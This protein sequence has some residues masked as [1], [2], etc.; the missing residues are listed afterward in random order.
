M[1]IVKIQDKESLVRD[2]TSG[3]IINTDKTE[4]E[5]YLI[6]RNASKQMKLQIEKNSEEIAEIKNDISEIKQLLIS[7]I[8][9]ER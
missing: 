5:N 3:A 9:K 6:K 8:N 7:L 1:N 2:M 4:Y